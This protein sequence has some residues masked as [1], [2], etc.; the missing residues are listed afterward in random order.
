MSTISLFMLCSLV[1]GST[2]FAI[3]LQQGAVDSLW[4]VCY[5]FFLAAVVLSVFC[6][7]RGGFPRF[8]LAQHIRMFIQGVCL[9][10]ISY[11][12]VYESELHISSGLT[13][14]LCT[15][16]LYFNII[17]ARLWLLNP[18]KTKIIIGALIGSLGVALV[19]LPEISP[20]VMAT[21]TSKGIILALGGSLFM[22]FGC[23]ACE[24]NERDGLPMLPVV[25]LNMLYGSAIV[26]VIAL[27][28]GIM[29]T[30]EFTRQYIGSLLYLV[31]FGS[32]AALT[33][34]VALIRRIGADRAA[35]VEIVYPVIAL[36]LSTI[37]EGFQWSIMALFG[38]LLI[39]AGNWVAMKPEKVLS[40][41]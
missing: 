30:F 29:P 32:I 24:R 41:S 19:V 36:G 3:T 20:A 12:L 10:G 1:W 14:I 35:F 38:I 5:R 37:L 2:W 17:I 23:V 33:S 25:S 7:F 8:T 6:C 26:A 15:S 4:S 13:A 18:I 39:A 34:Y 27:N 16:I 11:W 40:Q 31:M 21:G 22:S 9:C 28:L